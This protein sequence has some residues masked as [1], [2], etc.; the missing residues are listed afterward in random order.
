M[1]LTA[2]TKK[3]ATNFQKSDFLNNFFLSEFLITIEECS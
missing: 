2:P 1:Q 3:L